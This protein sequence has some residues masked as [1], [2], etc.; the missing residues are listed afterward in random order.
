MVAIV[1]NRRIRIEE[2]KTMIKEDLFDKY[3]RFSQK[4]NKAE[5]K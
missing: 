3:N 1:T 4:M 5:N 2:I